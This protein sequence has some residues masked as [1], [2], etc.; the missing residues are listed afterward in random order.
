M[1]TASLERWGNLS[2][3]PTDIAAQKQKFLE[4][5][6]SEMNGESKPSDNLNFLPPGTRSEYH[7]FQ[8]S[9]LKILYPPR[10]LRMRHPELK[11]VFDDTSHDDLASRRPKGKSQS[12]QGKPPSQEA[13]KAARRHINQC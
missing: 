13:L 2:A 7:H 12:A 5:M 1:S 11:P 4:K 9:H 8:V 10:T 6:M 3:N